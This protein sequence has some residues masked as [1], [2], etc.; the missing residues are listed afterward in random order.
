MSFRHILIWDIVAST[1]VRSRM[2]SVELDGIGPPTNGLTT[3][4][5]GMVNVFMSIETCL[6][7]QVVDFVD[8]V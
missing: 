3:R 1:Q 4:S 7:K 8:F 5:A 6:Y 2:A